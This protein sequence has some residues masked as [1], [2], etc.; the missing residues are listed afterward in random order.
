MTEDL[1]MAMVEW[2]DAYVHAAPVVSTREFMDETR[3][4]LCRTEETLRRLMRHSGEQFPVGTYK[5]IEDIPRGTPCSCMFESGP[6]HLN[7]ARAWKQ[8]FVSEKLLFEY[9][10]S[11]NLS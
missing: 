11:L 1:R 7:C 8:F 5:W 6:V 4:R 2:M 10:T 9:I 3:R